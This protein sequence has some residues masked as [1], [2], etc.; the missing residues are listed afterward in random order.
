MKRL[1]PFLFQAVFVQSFSES[2]EV[3]STSPGRRMRVPLRL[4]V[5]A[6]PIDDAGGAAMGDLCQ[7]Q[8]CR[9]K[10]AALLWRISCKLVRGDLSGGRGGRVGSGGQ[11]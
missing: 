3:R 7:R 8:F 1:A 2:G 11:D 9:R 5:P 6:L 10:C 4:D